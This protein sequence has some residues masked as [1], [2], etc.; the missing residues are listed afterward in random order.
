MSVQFA[1]GLTVALL[2]YG[3]TGLAFAIPFA[4]RG[5]NRIDPIAGESSWGFRVA[6]LAGCA[7]FWPVLLKRWFRTAPV[8]VER[9]SHRDAARS[10]K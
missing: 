7:T 4:F 6:I 8:P 10:D 5:V 9:N 2:I 1:G 3:A